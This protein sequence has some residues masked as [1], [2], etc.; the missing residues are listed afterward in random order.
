LN[1]LLVMH[2]IY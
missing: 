2:N 1:H